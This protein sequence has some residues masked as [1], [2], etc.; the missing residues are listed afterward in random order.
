MEVSATK[1][2]AG[3][4]APYPAEIRT[5]TSLRY[6]A[7]IWV[8]LFHW[9]AYFPDT[10]LAQAPLFREG[11]L[12]VDFF[13]ILSGFIL[14]HVYLQRQ[15]EGRLDYWNF[16]SRRIARIYPMHLITLV[17]MIGFGVIAHRL[18]LTFAGPWSPD[19]FYTLGSGE[20]P[21]EAMAQLLLIHAWGAS[22][23]LHFNAPSWSISAELFAYLM[24]PLFTYGLNRVAKRPGVA[25]AGV[26]LFILVY[27]FALGK[28]A[29]REV[30]EMSWNIGV[31]RIIPD[32]LYG[33]ALYRFGSVWSVGAHG[34]RIG[35]VV[36][37]AALLALVVL[38]LGLII[39]L[40]ADAERAGFLKP[41]RG[42]FAVLLGEVSYSVYILHFPFGIAFYGLLLKANLTGS[43]AWAVALL[44]IGSI[45]VTVLSWLSHKFIE[46]PA[47]NWLNA[48]ASAVMARWH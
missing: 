5:L 46:I 17:G 33:I 47:R 23:G 28:G 24:F 27:A 6:I 48:G 42:D 35:L 4:S 31:L 11:Y 40:C 26:L 36:M 16:V 20:V 15:A 34:S 30:F 1:A 37:T 45:A 7:A 22:D 2:G 39:L 32:F 10:A 41:I 12:G 21:R 9:T 19:E 13:F 44:I 8:V 14:C 43:L 38:A 3:R 25:L 18:N 29:G